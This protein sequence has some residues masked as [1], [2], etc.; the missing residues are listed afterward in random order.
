MTDLEYN[1]DTPQEVTATLTGFEPFIDTMKSN[2][3][4]S[5]YT[6][7]MLQILNTNMIFIDSK[8]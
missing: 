1:G 8:D 3:R 5:V 7:S 4:T 2:I 6:F